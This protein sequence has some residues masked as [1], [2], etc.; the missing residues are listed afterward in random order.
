[1]ITCDAHIDS[2]FV[3]SGIALQK[4]PTLT[5]EKMAT[6]RLDRAVF[7]LYIQDHKLDHMNARQIELELLRQIMIA[8]EHFPE[9]YLAL[10]GA[11]ALGP[12]PTSI[13]KDLAIAGIKYLTLVH[14]STN[15]V[16]GSC[17][18]DASI[19]LSPTGRRLIRDCEQLRILVDVSHCNDRSVDDVLSYSTGYPHIA[20][21]SGCRK[22]LF[23][24]RNLIDDHIIGIALGGGMVCVPFASKFVSTKEGVFAHIDHVCQL[25]GSTKHVGIGSDIDGAALA[26][27][28][29]GVESWG[30]VVMDQLSAKGYTDEQVADVAGGNLLRLLERKS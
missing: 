15:S 1:M 5:K 19:G 6:G 25:T 11:R 8:N 27:G 13:L 26:H 7:A 30:E 29:S 16:C 23:H 10:E 24:P 2:L 22:V 14:N 28:I 9:H 21:H 20:S 3:M 4:K 12:N 18:G 17:L